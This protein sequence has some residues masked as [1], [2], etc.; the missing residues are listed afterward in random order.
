M[1]NSF[2]VVDGTFM[3]VDHQAAT[4]CCG[5]NPVLKSFG[6]FVLQGLPALAERQFVILLLKGPLCLSIRCAFVQ[7]FGVRNADDLCGYRLRMQNC[8]PEEY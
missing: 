6:P 1:V 2:H 5:Q 7:H 3:L 8:H 4:C